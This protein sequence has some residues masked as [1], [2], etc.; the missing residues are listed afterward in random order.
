MMWRIGTFICFYLSLS[1]VICDPLAEV[2]C[3]KS[4]DGYL[5]PD[6]YQ[7]DR[8]AECN[9]HG[10]LKID[11]CA[12]GYAL[13]L[14]SGVCDLYNKVDCAGREKL[15]DPT[16]SGLC[17]RPTGNFP[18]PAEV[19]CSEYV[20]CRE[21]EAFMQNC[22]Y[23]AVFDEI[24]G[25]VHPDETSRVGCRAEDVFGF[26]C[27]EFGGK[28]RFG[29]HERLPH[30]DDCAFFYACLSTGQPRLLGCEKPK[31]FD[32]ESG[33]CKAQHLVPGCENRYPKEAAEHVDIDAERD[34]IADEIRAELEAKYGLK[35]GSL[36]D[37]GNQSKD[38]KK[39]PERDLNE[40]EDNTVEHINRFSGLGRKS[41]SSRDLE[42]ERTNSRFSQEQDIVVPRVEPRVEQSRQAAPQ[43]PA[44]RYRSLFSRSRRGNL[45]N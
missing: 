35:R 29:D 40:E 4:D 32:A 24:F 43:Q 25:C 1:Y 11:L 12:D 36:S 38:S 42:V 2:V 44:A 15:Q 7:C 14:T 9:P 22:G 27:P 28:K 13:D 18:V 34:R 3:E 17:L 20:D 8:F 45:D 30:P 39:E 23:G 41:G 33:L 26:K 21:G 5:V 19:S 16:G 37:S 10:K 6:P 31:V